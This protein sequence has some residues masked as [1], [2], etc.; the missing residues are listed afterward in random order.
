MVELQVS[1]SLTE[2]E[3]NK[4]KYKV[5]LDILGKNNISLDL[6]NIF[7]KEKVFDLFQ[8]DDLRKI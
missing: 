8:E 2:N 3:A 6:I 7:P 5:V 4:E 1:I